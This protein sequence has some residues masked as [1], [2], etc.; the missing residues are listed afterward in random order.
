MINRKYSTIVFGILVSIV[1]SSV[2]SFVSIV[3]SQATV[4]DSLEFAYI[5]PLS[6]LKSWLVAFP[7]ILIVAPAAHKIVAFVTYEPN[8]N[9]S[10]K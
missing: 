7:T 1:M 10:S 9:S 6:W 8:H 3:S 4:F 5:W 2:V